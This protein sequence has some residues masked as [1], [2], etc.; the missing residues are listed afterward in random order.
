MVSR[1]K[2]GRKQAALKTFPGYNI[3]GFQ[4]NYIELTAYNFIFSIETDTEI[5]NTF[6]HNSEII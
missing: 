4:N 2:G 1:N 3:V 6:P 5:Y